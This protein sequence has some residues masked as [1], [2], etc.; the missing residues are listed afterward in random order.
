VGAGAVAAGTGGGGG[1][2]LVRARWP[3][4]VA[5]L[6][7]LGAAV[8]VIW[9]PVRRRIAFTESV[10]SRALH[11]DPQGAIS[12]AERAA[13]AD[14]LDPLS[15]A[16]AAKL[17]VMYCPRGRGESTETYLRNG[18]AWSLAAVQR[19][20]AAPSHWRLAGII[21]WHLAAPDA[22]RYAWRPRGGDP[23]EA[24]ESLKERLK[25]RPRDILLLSDA[26]GAAFAAGRYDEAMHYCE[27][28]VRRDPTSP[29]LWIHL[30]DAAW[31]AA[32][33][34]IAERAWLG[35]R[36][37]WKDRPAADHDAARD[38]RDLLDGA[39]WRNPMNMRFRID[40]A[41]IL[42]AMSRPQA[43]I[44]QLSEA[45][46]IDRRL[47]PGSVHHLS[48]AERRWVAMLEA[49]AKALAEPATR[50]ASAPGTAAGDGQ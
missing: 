36:K 19:D 18:L 3:L 17:N 31:H 6:L 10:V 12:Y 7:A 42:C 29:A 44:A 32:R 23:A 48:Q 37:L 45:R 4:A 15:A 33:E 39:V 43:A 50:P 38:A 41:E 28:A 1:R 49:H 35:A 2:R 5:A 30:G 24:L 22:F 25:T 11:K 13:E 46:R 47:L 27:E 9:R 26:A 40:Y 16:D 34:R 14:P 20:R 8:M 21:Q